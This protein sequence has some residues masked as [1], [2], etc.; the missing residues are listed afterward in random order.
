MQL[1]TACLDLA[2]RRLDVWP[3]ESNLVLQPRSSNCAYEAIY[4]I[5]GCELRN[6]HQVQIYTFNQKV[7]TPS[8]CP[9]L[10]IYHRIFQVMHGVKERYEV[11]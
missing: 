8:F 5:A 2:H 11:P 3:T 1:P 9:I 7:R 10:K 4:D 6:R